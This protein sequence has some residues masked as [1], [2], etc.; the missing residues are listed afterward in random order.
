MPEEQ[1][2]IL[3][4]PQTSGGL[5]VSVDPNGREQF[6]EVARRRGLK[7]KPIGR[8]Q[9]KGPLRVSVS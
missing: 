3:C 8:L 1:C 2:L 6:L 9:E 4:D 7:L 5:L